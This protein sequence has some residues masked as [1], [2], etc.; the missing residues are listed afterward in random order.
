MCNN[1]ELLYIH[2]FEIHI[3]CT[4][5]YIYVY[6]LYTVHICIHTSLLITYVYL[7]DRK[8]EGRVVEIT[9]QDSVQLVIIISPVLYALNIQYVCSGYAF[10]KSK[11]I[12]LIAS[13]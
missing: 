6:I 13:N 4:C 12:G 11:F 2:R 7:F 3:P 8:K 1:V 5:M 10:S 9:A